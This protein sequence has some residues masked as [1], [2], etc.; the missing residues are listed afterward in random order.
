V[1]HTQLGQTLGNLQEI[2][3][4]YMICLLLQPSIVAVF[5]GQTHIWAVSYQF[6]L[7]HAHLGWFKPPFPIVEPIF[8]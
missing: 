1:F 3:N 6:L 7:V 5:V 4:F 8:L 2:P